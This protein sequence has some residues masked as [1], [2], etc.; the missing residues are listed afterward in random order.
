[1]NFHMRR[2][3]FPVAAVSAAL[4]LLPV[5]ASAHEHQTFKIGD[6]TYSFTV[7]SLNEPVVVDDKSGVEFMVSQ[8]GVPGAV[9]P[10]SDGDGNSESAGVPVENLQQ[11]LKVEVAAGDKK[12]V[13][14]LSPAYGTPGTYEAVFYPTVQTTYSYR[15]FGT[16]NN[17][18]VNVT[19]SCNPTGHTQ[20][21]EDKKEVK[22]SDGVTR[23][24]KAGAFGCPYGKAEMGFPEP[25]TTLADITTT[26][27][28][29]AP[30]TDLSAT[31]L[32][33]WSLLISIVALAVGAGA[34]MKKRK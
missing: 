1:M 10:A 21:P 22:I 24:D 8:L 31:G 7:G 9:K 23:T 27:S 20:T 34:H 5:A 29:L 18:P 19:F 4:F 33:V 2:L 13:F 12:R 11:T 3:S 26:L 6:K 28:G 15:F 25:S 17:T 32:G 16:L 14:D 30:T